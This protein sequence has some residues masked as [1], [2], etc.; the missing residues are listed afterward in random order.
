MVEILTVSRR[1][2]R[3]RLG[4]GT[5]DI[6]FLPD[7]TAKTGIIGVTLFLTCWDND[8]FPQR[9]VESRETSGISRRS[10]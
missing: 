4:C 8:A 6:I 2:Y 1:E 9:R 10:N 3:I 7:F 5:R